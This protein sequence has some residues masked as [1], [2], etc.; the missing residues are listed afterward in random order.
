MALKAILTEYL[1][2]EGYAVRSGLFWKKIN[3]EVIATIFP[4]NFRG[5]FASPVFG[6][7]AVR[8]N[9]LIIT[10][11]KDLPRA[12]GPWSVVSPEISR[13]HVE[14]LKIQAGE[15]FD[16]G[17]LGSLYEDDRPE[18]MAEFQQ[19]TLAKFA[20]EIEAYGQRFFGRLNSLEAI[21]AEIRSGGQIEVTSPLQYPALFALLK[22]R[23]GYRWAVDWARTTQLLPQKMLESFLLRLDENFDAA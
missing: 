13:V 5:F 8:V 19:A 15:K 11:Q 12:R 7:T 1:K 2:S 14:H 22:D 21:A 4:N 10:L 20:H 16:P 23:D 18:A 6:V 3:D 17:L 9:K